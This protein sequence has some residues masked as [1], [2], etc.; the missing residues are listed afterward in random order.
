MKNENHNET[1]HPPISVEP[2]GLIQS[3]YHQH[4]DVPHTHRGWTKDEAIIQLFEQHAHGLNGLKGYSHIIVLFYI[5]RASEW[6]FP[7]NRQKPPGIEVFATRMPRRPVPIGMSIVELREFSPQ[8][9][10][11][12][13][14]GLDAL[15]GTPVLDIK[16]YIHYFDSYPE[17]AVPGWVDEHIHRHHHGQPHHEE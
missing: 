11:V 15:D 13:V 1:A 16:P 4:H 10:Q 5:H 7:K 17:A 3:P 12:R 9:G 2:I 14:Q 6:R 8:T